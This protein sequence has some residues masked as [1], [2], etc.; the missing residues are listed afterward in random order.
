MAVTQSAPRRGT[1][2]KFWA[3]IGVSGV[4]LLVLVSK[5]HPENV[6]PKHSHLSTLAFFAAAL[7]M[8]AFGIALSAWRWQRVLVVFDKHVPLRVLL[9]HYFAGQFVGNVLPS[10]IGGDVMRVS[11]GSKSL[12]SSEIAFASVALE[13]LSGFV[14]LPLLTFLGFLTRPSLAEQSW[15]WVALAIA[16]VTLVALAVILYAAGHPRLAGRF[17]EH[18]N[19]MRF[20]G[21]VHLGIGR[22]RHEPRAA[23]GVLIAAMAYQLS[24]V[25]MVLLAVHTLAI[26]L[27]V[28]AVFAFIPAVAMAQVLPLSLNGLGVRE[29]LLVV[30]LAPL[31]GVSHGQAVGLG[32]LWYAMMLIVSLLGAPSFAVGHRHRASSHAEEHASPREPSTPAP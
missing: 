2:W 28:A 27:P 3:R 5:I 22:L 32:L 18:E 8:A 6:L 11:R 29:G 15:A 7:L 25:L 17:A 23:V 12:D 19:F 30:F 16:G 14:A 13:R 9:S 21:A 1:H 4:L 10:T 24:V 26:S 31:A 20:V